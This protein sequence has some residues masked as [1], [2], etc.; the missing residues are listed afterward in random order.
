MNTELLLKVK[1]QIL[2]EPRQFDMFT[3]FSYSETIP[4]CHT[5][6][7]IAGWAITLGKTKPNPLEA[8]KEI[9]YN[10]AV[11][12]MHAWGESRDKVYEVAL[13]L[14]DITEEQAMRLFGEEDWPTNFYEDYSKATTP[15]ARAEVAARRIDHFIA[16]NGEE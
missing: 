5:T 10:F 2:R 11:T 13:P 14:L 12:N 15:R 7:C 4:N 3:W 8:A 16:T 9:R 6:A 1:E